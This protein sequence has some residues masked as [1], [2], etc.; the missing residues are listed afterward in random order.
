STKFQA[1]KRQYKC[2]L[3]HNKK[4]LNN[5]KEWE[6]FKIMQE[7]FEKKPWVQ[8]LAVAG[9]H[10]GTEEKENILENKPEKSNKKRKVKDLVEDY[11]SQSKEERKYQ[12][13][14]RAK[15]H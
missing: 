7:L 11:I 3:D 13:E 15:Q 9:S 8:P 12:R 14:I 6:Y 2:V 10:V 1:L 5:R 4:S